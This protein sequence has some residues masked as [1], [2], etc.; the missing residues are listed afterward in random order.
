[1][2]QIQLFVLFPEYEEASSNIPYIERIGLLSE[3]EMSVYIRDFANLVSF[4]SHERYDGFYDGLNVV[5]FSKPL[6]EVED[7][8]P[9]SKTF[10]RNVLRKWSNWRDE[11]VSDDTCYYYH[12]TPV[13]NETLSEIAGRKRQSPQENRF[14]VI[15]HKAIKS[16]EDPLPVFDSDH[17]Q[18]RVPEGIRQLPC[19]IIALHG[20]FEENRLPKRKFR[21]NPKHGENGKGHQKGAAPLLCSCSQAEALL[22]KAVGEDSSARNPLFYYDKVHNRYIEFRSENTPDNAYHAFHLEEGEI[23]SRLG[24]RI[25]EK[26]EV[27]R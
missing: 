24:S 12:Q 14:C 8:Y 27:T 20:W 17:V 10:L 19:R 25:V 3:E 5:S 11:K 22:H 26:I 23:S 4:L 21:I 7:C 13:S 6:D 1:M 16:T 18:K 2:E 9:N 15:N